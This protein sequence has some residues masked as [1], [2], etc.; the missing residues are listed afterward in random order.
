[1]RYRPMPSRTSPGRRKKP[2]TSKTIRLM[3]RLSRNSESGSNT[4]P[5]SDSRYCD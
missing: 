2:M 3:E 4:K 5:G 1:M